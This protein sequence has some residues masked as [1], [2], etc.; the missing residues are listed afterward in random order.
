M[1]IMVPFARVLTAIVPKHTRKRNTP[2]TQ[3]IDPENLQSRVCVALLGV[4]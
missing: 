3:T 2:E 1:R 4:S